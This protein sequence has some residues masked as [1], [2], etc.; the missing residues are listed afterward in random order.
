MLSPVTNARPIGRL[1]PFSAIH[2]Q[3]MPRDLKLYDRVRVVTDRFR[4]S[5]APAGTIGYIIEECADDALEVEVSR[6]DGTTIAQFV[7]TPADLELAEE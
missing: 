7:A 4:G 1:K 6:K 2:D 3:P 5:G